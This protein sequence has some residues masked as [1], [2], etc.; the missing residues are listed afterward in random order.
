[1]SSTAQDRTTHQPVD[2]GSRRLGPLPIVNHFMERLG[3]NALLEEFVPTEDSRVELP[4]AKGLGV[5]L[6]SIIVERDPIYRQ[7]ETVDTF[8]SQMFGIAEGEAALL[9]DDRIGRALD[10]LFDADRG[11]LMTEA[12][13]RMGR[14]FGVIFDELHNDSTTIRLTG[15]YR[16]AQGRSIRGRRAPW[17]TFGLSKDHRPDLKQLLFMLTTTADGGVPVQ[18]RC[19]DGNASDVST[20]IETWEALRKVA[21]RTDFLY[22]AD[23][24][25]CVTDKRMS[26]P[27]SWSGTVAIR[28][29]NTAPG[30]GGGRSGPRSLRG[31]PGRSSGSTA[32]CCG[33]SKTARAWSV[34][35]GR[36]RRSRPSSKGWPV[37][38]RGCAKVPRWMVPS[39]I[40]SGVLRS[41]DT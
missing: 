21:G 26:L 12:V 37:Q 32:R 20:H 28:A 25:L 27:G 13:V 8:A 31:R 33:S 29:G 3:L 41:G 24:K 30:T 9:S 4:Y 23:S 17:I 14:R 7:Q 18:F 15:Q 5:L 2:L 6:R 38:S 35:P 36:P 16:D 39:R 34:W 40:S 22:V 10:Q 1:M 19:G 11:S